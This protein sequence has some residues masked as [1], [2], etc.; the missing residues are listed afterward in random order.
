MKCEQLV[1]TLMLIGSTAALS[2][3]CVAHAQAGA[4]GDANA[5]VS[6]TSPPMLVE[7]EPDIWVVRDH[8]RAVYYTSGYYWVNRDDVW[9]R[10]QAYDEGWVRVEA[11]T[12]PSTIAARDH[13][14]YVSYR[15]P[16]T[17]RTRRA[18]REHLASEPS[19]KR[20]H[21]DNRDHDNKGGPPDHA[22]DQHGGP[23]GQNAVPGL[24]NQ[25]RSDEGNQ[26]ANKP[27]EKKDE[28]KDDKKEGPDKKD[29]PKEGPK[30]APKKK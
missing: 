10:A 2:V 7:I 29:G 17:A 12:V 3:G 23:P 5:P 13:R 4:Y 21:D 14:A 16:E 26:L 27:D 11:N 8:E 9:Y 1:C 20:G 25:R 19:P 30:G 15:G 24:G 22:A 28:K 6:F 18:P